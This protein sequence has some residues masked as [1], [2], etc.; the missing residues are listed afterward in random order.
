[1]RE[2]VRYRVLTIPGK[3][4]V[5][6]NLPIDDRR[7]PEY[8]SNNDGGSTTSVI[9]YPYVSIGIL[10]AS[11]TDENGNRIR[12]PWNPNDNLSMTKFSFP[13]FL[14]ELRGIA[15]DMKIPELYTY[16]GKRLELNEE[17]AAKV[18]RVFMIGS[19]TL[20]LSTVVV[21]NELDDTRVEGVKVKFN[22]E[23]SSFTLT[24]N[25]LTSLLYSLDH[26]DLDVLSLSIYQI[27]LKAPASSKP[28]FL[29]PA[30]FQPKVDILPKTE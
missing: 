16:H 13:I 11:E 1:M 2:S 18:R 19:T 10:R 4:R 3:I 5:E 26:M 12:A 27:W 24:L 29:D 28:K 20:E 14:E 15:K 9:L 23:Q 7:N 8:T 25:E 17:L 30:A 6:V 21:V 22:N